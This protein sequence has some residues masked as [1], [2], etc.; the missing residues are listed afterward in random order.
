MAL[1]SDEQKSTDSAEL[2]E[3][4]ANLMMT[5]RED[6]SIAREEALD[7][8]I[9]FRS[10]TVV[11]ELRQRAAEARAAGANALMAQGLTDLRAVATKLD[12]FASVFADA[13][14]IAATGKKELLFPRLAAT[15]S[16]MLQVV[17]ELKD[18]AAKVRAQVTGVD[19]L[20]DVP[21]ALDELQVALEKLQ[22]SV[23]AVQ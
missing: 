20:G 8:L 19:E 16:T 13:A 21:G 18:A 23:K 11:P 3:L 17:T 14:A 1:T 5:L 15:A 2:E 9:D 7:A 10:R 4:I 22:D 12:P 6:D